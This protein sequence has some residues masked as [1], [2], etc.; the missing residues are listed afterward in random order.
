MKPR[1]VTK[2]N[3]FVLLFAAW[4]IIWIAF[5][6]RELFLKNNLGD[7]K[8]LMSRSLE[9]KKSYVTGDR[10]YEFLTFCNNKLPVGADYMWSKT[11]K[12][13][14]GMR[15]ATYYLYPHLE[16]EGADF[17]LVYEEPNFT[18]TDYAVLAK[19]DESRYILVRKGKK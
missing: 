4:V 8:M 13:D 14:I 12:E 3:V 1:I 6:A 17:M 18:K 11:N 15:R 19:L 9:G 10:L 16:R 2:K 7:Y 5:T